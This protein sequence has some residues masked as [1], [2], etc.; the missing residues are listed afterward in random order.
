MG[1]R[2]ISVAL[3][4]MALRVVVA[5]AHLVRRV[6]VVVVQHAAQ[7]VRQVVQRVSYSYTRL[8]REIKIILRADEVSQRLLSGIVKHRLW[9]WLL[10]LAYEEEVF[11]IDH[12]SN[13]RNL[14]QSLN[15]GAQFTDHFCILLLEPVLIQLSW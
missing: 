12:A 9:S 2:S 13:L 3:A 5:F 7:S 14:D 15:V 11:H 1:P 8:H 4:G 6:V 10:N